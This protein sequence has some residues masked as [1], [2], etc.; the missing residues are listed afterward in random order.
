[1]T[2]KY[3][4][5]IRDYTGS[6]EIEIEHFETLHELLNKL[7]EIYGLKFKKRIFKDDALSDEIIIL[8]NGRNIVHLSNLDTKLEADDEISIFPVV[9]GG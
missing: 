6:K 1:M 3:F 9:A 7:C 5:Y 8:V 4:A 2:V